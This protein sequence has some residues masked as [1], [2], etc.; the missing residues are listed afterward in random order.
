MTEEDAIRS[1]H[2]VRSY[3]GKPLSVEEKTAIEAKIRE[4]NADS[5]LHIQLVTDEP[6]TFKGFASY[7]SF[8][9]VTNYIVVAGKRAENL[10]EKA[11]YNGEKLVLLCQTI[12]LNTCWV[13]LTYKKIKGAFELWP[14]E[15]VVYMIAVG[16]GTTQGSAHK[17]KTAEAVSNITDK[18]PDWFRRGVE[19]AL[20]A[21]TAIN[22]QKFYFELHDNGNGK[23]P[24]V[25]A[26]K[27][28]SFAGYTDTD[29]GIAKLHFEIGAGKDTFEWK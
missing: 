21:P 26:K 17:I 24:T 18:S 3:D 22:Q 13:G 29:L 16:H 11:G 8:K 20:L 27:R 14:D 19:A 10:G 15:K 6:R 5:G 2:S 9:G 1:R 7:G 4:I 25:S 12:G 23:M 28:F